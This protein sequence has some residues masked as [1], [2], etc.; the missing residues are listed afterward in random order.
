[1]FCRA[2]SLNGIT[3]IIQALHHS[4]YTSKR[5]LD[6]FFIFINKGIFVWDI[7][8]GRRIGFS[9]FVQYPINVFRVHSPYSCQIIDASNNFPGMPISYFLES[10]RMFAYWHMGLCYW[11]PAASLGVINVFLWRSPFQIIGPII[12]LI[13]VLMIN[14]RFI[15]WIRMKGPANKAMNFVCFINFSP[16]LPFREAYMVISAPCN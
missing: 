11:Y 15:F 2:K 13:K 1:M 3:N 14:L 6:G 8:I 7:F 10:P 9:L 5:G 16:V 12:K 4:F